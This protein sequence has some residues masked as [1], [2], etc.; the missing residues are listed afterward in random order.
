VHF[1][2]TDVVRHKLV[3]DILRAYNDWEKQEQA[4]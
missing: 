3:K 2:E 1:S 4:R